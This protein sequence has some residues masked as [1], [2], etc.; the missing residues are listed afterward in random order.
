MFKKVYPKKFDDF[1]KRLKEIPHCDQRVLHAPGECAYCDAHPEWQELRQLW[2]IAF[3]N[4]EPEGNELP[5]PSDKAR[6][7]GGAHVWSGNVPRP[8]K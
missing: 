5:C 6:G 8:K 7:T 2:G 1:T 4:Y 3:T